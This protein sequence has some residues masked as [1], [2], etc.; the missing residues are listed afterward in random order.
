MQLPTISEHCPTVPQMIQL[1]SKN[2]SIKEAGQ[3]SIGTHPARAPKG[4]TSKDRVQIIATLYTATA[5]K[6]ATAAFAGRTRVND[7]HC[8]EPRI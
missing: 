3:T 5:R 6:P 2:L 8:R 4:K 1:F 7:S